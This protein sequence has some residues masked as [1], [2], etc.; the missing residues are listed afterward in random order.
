MDD[1]L[2]LEIRKK[3][4]NLI[5]ENPG[6]HANKIAKLLSISGQLADYHLAYLER[7]EMIVAV[8]E[9]GFRRYYVKG[10]TGFNEQKRIS[11]LQHETPLKIVLF[12]L[13]YPSSTHK[14]ILEQIE[15]A[16]STLTYHLTKLIKHDIVSVTVQENEKT[17]EVVNEKKIIEL[18]TEYKLDFQTEDL[19]TI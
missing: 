2:E 13:Q 8:K 3:I 5:K 11:I 9:G 19:G 12:L 14:E 6:L 7:N 4:Y 16:K 17:Y 10:T 15:V 18:L 1:V